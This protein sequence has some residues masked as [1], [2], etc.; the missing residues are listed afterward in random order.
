MYRF[1]I[2]FC[3]AGLLSVPGT[4]PAKEV[5]TFDAATWTRLLDAAPRPLVVVFTT[6]DCEYCPAVIERIARQIRAQGSQARL[7]AVVMD[8][9]DESVQSGRHYARAD[10]VYVFA[11]GESDRLRFAIDPEW[12][13]IT[14]YVVLVDRAGTTHRFVGTPPAGE[15]K[16]LLTP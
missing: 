9:I 3:L 12:R 15:L 16:R 11:K 6:T 4:L 2:S 10:R 1:L 5:Q 7:E 14:P 8:G 13:G